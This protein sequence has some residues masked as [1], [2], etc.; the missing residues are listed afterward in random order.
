[1]PACINL[2]G[3]NAYLAPIKLDAAGL[4]ALGFEPVEVVKASKLY[5]ASSLTAIR[6]ALV[7]HLISMHEMEAA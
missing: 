1:M 3:I 2:S 5:R 4:S 7:D 6:A